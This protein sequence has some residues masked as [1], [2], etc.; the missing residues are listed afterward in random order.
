MA[1]DQF[2]GRGQT[3]K[4]WHSEKGK[5]L[6]FSILLQPNFLRLVDQF[7]LTIAVSLAMCQYLER[8]IPSEKVKIKWPNDIYVEN[9]KI[10]GIL[11]ENIVQKQDWKYAIIGIGINVNQAMFPDFIR[12]RATSL[13]LETGREADF[14]LQ[15][16]LKFICNLIELEYLA[17]EK[18][19]QQN[20]ATDWKSTCYTRRLYLRNVT[21]EF[22][23]HAIPV[24]GK[25]RGI[26]NEGKLLIDFNGH[27]T[28]FGL[29][30]VKF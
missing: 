28:D 10:A 15:Q 13:K 24:A 9:R 27:V 4:E 12:E 18:A 17:L 11:I 20:K 1:V 5:N 2:A 25:I 30:E 16:E 21:H 8:F 22:L 7:R 3:T 26:T 14:D 19:S 6:T 29:K 23:I